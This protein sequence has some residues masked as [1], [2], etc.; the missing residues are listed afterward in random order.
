[1]SDNV[2]GVEIAVGPWHRETKEGLA[3]RAFVRR[4]HSV[5]EVL[6]SRG[7]RIPASNRLSR[8]AAMLE[9]IDGQTRSGQDV[10][11]QEAAAA[12]AVQSIFDASLVAYA[13]ETTQHPFVSIPNARLRHLVLGADSPVGEKKT[14]A[15]DVA[16]EALV[17][18]LL[19]LGGL[20]ARPEEPDYLTTLDGE[21]I[22]IAA[23]RC[24]ATSLSSVTNLVRKATDQLR[25]A[26]VRGFVFISVDQLLTHL[27]SGQAAADVGGH[28][29]A[30]V[31]AVHHALETQKKD[32][33]L[34]GG[35]LFGRHVTFSGPAECRKIK[36]QAPMQVMAYADPPGE[37]RRISDFQERFRRELFQRIGESTAKLTVAGWQS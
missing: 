1:M 11:T 37:A 35:I 34:L 24:T 4:A 6:R 12:H 18:A 36:L 13:I 25:R 28:F 17:G 7:V 31:A 21:T 26:D 3:F 14:M 5:I 22:G 8:A 16:F 9:R 30:Q 20:D 10:Q 33:R 15:R 32:R 19:V 2:A 29:M 27:P 23:K